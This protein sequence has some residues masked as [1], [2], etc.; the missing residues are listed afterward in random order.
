M[1]LKCLSWRNS[2]NVTSIIKNGES[3]CSK[4]DLTSGK[5]FFHGKD[6]KGRLVAYK[7]FIKY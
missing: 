4:D 7:P 2:F 6:K 5:V 1:F 3:G